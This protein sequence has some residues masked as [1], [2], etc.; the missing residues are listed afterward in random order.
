MCLICI[1]IDSFVCHILFYTV[2]MIRLWNSLHNNV[3]ASRTI[4]VLHRLLSNV[5]F[6]PYLR[7]V[8]DGLCKAFTVPVFVY[9]Y[10][11]TNK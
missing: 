5:N 8:L 4:Y 10:T 11:C 1:T 3:T 2:R 7:G 6:I 9:F